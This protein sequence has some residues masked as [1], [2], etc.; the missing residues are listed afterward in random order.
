MERA[1]ILWLP[2]VAL[3]VVLVFALT[4]LIA[5]KEG[6]RT[7]WLGGRPLRGRDGKRVRPG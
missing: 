2:S 6:R 3:T 4:T 1:R 5:P 7:P